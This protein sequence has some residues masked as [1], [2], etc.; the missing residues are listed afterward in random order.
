ME[1]KSTMTLL[2]HIAELRKRILLVAAVFILSMA[3]GLIAAL[4]CYPC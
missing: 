2:E 1:F 3:A 4:M